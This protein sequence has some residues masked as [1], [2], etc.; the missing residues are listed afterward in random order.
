[1][2]GWLPYVIFFSFLL[3]FRITPNSFFLLLFNN[4]VCFYKLK[5]QD[6]INLKSDSDA[7]PCVQKDAIK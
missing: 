7:T 2:L 6:V 5:T 4:A 1:M 3:Y